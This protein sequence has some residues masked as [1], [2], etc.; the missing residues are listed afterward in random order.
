MAKY[1]YRCGTEGCVNKG[2]DLERR[3]KAGFNPRVILCPECGD[4]ASL[5]IG[6]VQV[7]YKGDG[8]GGHPKG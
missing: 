3:Y 2:I 7:H 6:R 8:W 5:R 4:P 1:V